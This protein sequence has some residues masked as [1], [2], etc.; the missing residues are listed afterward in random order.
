MVIVGY[1][2]NLQWKRCLRRTKRS[3]KVT[4][5]AAWSG[6]IIMKRSA[7]S[8][9]RKKTKSAVKKPLAKVLSAAA[10][11]LKKKSPTS[12][13]S[14][15]ASVAALDPAVVKPNSKKAGSK[16]V[17]S[18]PKS[19]AQPVAARKTVA[20]PQ[21]TSK[22]PKR[23]AKSAVRVK[24]SAT[25]KRHPK[26]PSLRS[27]KTKQ[28][29]RLGP[30]NPEPS[31][32]RGTPASAATLPSAVPTPPPALPASAPRTETSREQLTAK[33]IPPQ[34]ALTTAVE[35]RST[36][37]PS[38]PKTT[39]YVPPILFEGDEPAVDFSLPTLQKRPPGDA[40]SAKISEP[41][42]PSP[43]LTVMA[44]DPFCIYASWDL[45]PD[46]QQRFNALSPEGRLIL[47]PVMESGERRAELEV[48][49]NPTSTHWFVTVSSPDTAYTVHLGY[50]DEKRQW[51][52]VARSEVVK[53]PP[54]AISEVTSVQVGRVA[55][56]EPA[57]GP[58]GL[59][60]PLIPPFIEPQPVTRTTT[61]GPTVSVTIPPEFAVPPVLPREPALWEGEKASH[62]PV[63]SEQTLPGRS[64]GPELLKPTLTPRPVP[65][66]ASSKPALT[67]GRR[68]TGVRRSATLGQG[69]RRSVVSEQILYALASP[70]GS[71]R[72]G[73]SSAELPLRVTKIS[74]EAV[75]ITSP[76]PVQKQVWPGPVVAE[77]IS[78]PAGE[79]VSPPGAPS[80][81]WLRVNAELV[82]YGATEPNAQVAIS[83]RPIK[84][85]PDGT[86]SYR[87]ALPDGD[88]RLCVVAVS[89]E[90]DDQRQAAMRFTRGTDYAGEVGAVTQDAALR[91]PKPENL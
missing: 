52:E 85:R 38:P 17:V 39:F 34:T 59:M 84:L 70:G 87:F 16:R 5:T 90:G 27:R 25:T 68:S 9:A 61:V 33:V 69:Q 20:S 31:I 6:D 32:I 49:L 73:I 44:R 56:D 80:G 64:L 42:L 82:I 37:K 13:R 66:P 65:G 8:S 63:F 72:P 67:P 26:V 2:R 83:G 29:T 21:G 19:P 35:S 43:K 41:P 78:S 76:T 89:P 74:R 3:L 22:V 53:T 58:A 51:H 1:Y 54:N 30:V 48:R 23:P 77:T 15:K 81:F 4:R 28:V 50:Y 11:R 40:H 10:K 88:Y 14:K 60:A 62:T 91:P 57:P 86:F 36:T 24:K 46:R 45:G 79:F 12:T 55:E 18:A 47:R 71:S 7:G 75:T